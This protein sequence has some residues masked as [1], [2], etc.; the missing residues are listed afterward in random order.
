MNWPQQM[1]VTPAAKSFPR[2]LLA[3]LGAGW[4]AVM[5]QAAQPSS[6]PLVWPGPPDA[7]RLA[8]VQSIMQPADVGLKKSGLRRFFGWFIGDD[9]ASSRLVKPFAVALDEADNLCLTDTGANVVCFHDATRKE[10]H[11][12]E[13]VGKARFASPVAV[14]KRGDA[15]FVAD[16]S[17]RRVIAFN[18]KGTLL[19]EITEGLERPAGLAVSAENLFV[20]DAQ[21]CRVLVFDLNGKPAWQFGAR[22]AGPGEFNLPTHIAFTPQGDLLITDSMNSRI[23]I[24]DARG[25]FKGT[26][27]K[28]GDS[29]GHF[30]RPKGAAADSFGRVYALDALFDSLQVFDR[31]G[32]VLLS[33]GGGG[34]KPGEF[35][36]P[37]GIAISRTNR[38]F[39][40]DTYNRRVQVFQYVG[41][42]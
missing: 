6:T 8:F 32:A 3:V 12:W 41:E 26:L 18:L 37:N 7:P 10:W 42:P 33:L 15:L 19:F 27:G 14:A 40:A 2:R 22:G 35:W 30:G 36:L 9:E 29:P 21:L 38:I 39:A 13:R 5:A 28:S 20:V 23:V 34:A 31:G 24:C 25:G 11:R 4:L 16:S 17:L 1:T